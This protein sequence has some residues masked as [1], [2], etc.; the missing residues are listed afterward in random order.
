MASSKWKTWDELTT[1]SQ[2]RRIV[3]WGAS[4]WIER[5]LDILPLPS[6]FIV[7]NNPANQGI[8][9]SGLPVRPPKDLL[10]VNREK[11]YIVICTVNY[12]SVIDEL[13]QFG[14]VMGDHYC[15]TPLLAERK[16]KDALKS[17]NQTVLVSSPEQR[18]DQTSGGGIYEYQTLTGSIKKVFSGKCRAMI[19]IGS[20]LLVLDM[21]K[22]LLILDENYKE[23]ACIQLQKNCEP[24]GL[25]YDDSTN[26]IYVGQPG[27]DSIAVYS[28][29]SRTLVNEFFISEKWSQ[30]QKDNHHINDLCIHGNSLFVSLFS[31][32][33]NWM[34]E[35]YDGGILELD[36]KTGKILGPVVSGLW[37]PHSIKRFNGHLC[38]VNSMRGEVFNT[39][40]TRLARFS[41]F[42]RGLDY[43]GKYFYI[44]VS[45]HRYP[46]KLKDLSDNISL[47]SGF[48]ILDPETRMSRFFPLRQ[49][50]TVHSV[51]VR[52]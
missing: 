24:H 6:D 36:K 49:S 21:L 51:L 31:F 13:D 28:L 40:W 44:G 39:T 33:G 14:F 1:I 19:Y 25:S 34:N 23:I 3:F 22:G 30:N 20:K 5:T 29:E 35:M 48:H 52:Q 16:N 15:C 42:V 45:E 37:M 7:D 46:E 50:E 10:T 11:I 2:D 8:I 27:R 41:A 38:Y 18:T 4:N 9:F 12:P 47:D 26:L 17:V 32:S 43:D